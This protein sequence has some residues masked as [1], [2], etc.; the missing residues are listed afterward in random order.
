MKTASEFAALDAM[1]R[2]NE[3][4]RLKVYKDSL[5][6]PSVAM[7]FNLLRPDAK[8]R[9]AD[10]GA[11][12][13][14]VRS[15]QPLTEAQASHL[16]RLDLDDC[17][18]DL[19]TLLDLDSLPLEA[20]LVLCDLRYNLGPTRLRKF[21]TTLAAFRQHKFKKAARQLEASLWA[22]QVGARARRSVEMLRRLTN[23]ED[24]P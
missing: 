7:G 21:V 3:G 15:G 18:N 1:I 16:L 8:D 13:A 10:V 14:E 17:V 22:R 2:R 11:I 20:Q 12:L 5:G 6:I 19:R 23:G 9:L 24:E 4:V